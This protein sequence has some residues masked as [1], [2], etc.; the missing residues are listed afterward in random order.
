MQTKVG[1]RMH[2]YK[3]SEGDGIPTE[4]FQILKDAV[5]VLQSICQQIWKTQ[6][7][8]QDW[9]RSV[10]IPIPKK[11]NAR[12]CSNYCKIVLISHATKVMLKILQDRI[13][14]H[15]NQE[16]PNVQAGFQRGRGTRDQIAISQTIEKAR[17]FQKNSNSASLTMLTPLTVRIT[18]NWKI[19]KDMGKPDHCTCLLRNLY[20]GQQ[21]AVRTG[22]EIMT[23]SKLRKVSIKTVYCPLAYLTYMQ[24]TSSKMLGWMTHSWTQDR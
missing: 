21:G 6:Q 5:K 8:T 7:W 13:Q 14:Q 17:E 3:A 18:T 9:K 23:G 16:L 10:L 2:Y 24:S 22:H 19:L 1:I 11:G 12:E 20:A 4:L 15:M